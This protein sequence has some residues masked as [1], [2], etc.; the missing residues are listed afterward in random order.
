MGRPGDQAVRLGAMLLSP[1]PAASSPSSSTTER[2]RASLP[3]D[4]LHMPARRPSFLIS[5]W[6]RRWPSGAG[7]S[8]RRRLPDPLGSPCP[9]L[10]NSKLLRGRVRAPRRLITR[11]SSRPSES[12]GW[13]STL[14]GWSASPPRRRLCCSIGRRRTP[15]GTP[16]VLALWISSAGMCGGSAASGRKAVLVLLSARGAGAGG[17]GEL[18]RGALAGGRRRLRPASRPTRPTRPS[19]LE[20]RP[21]RR[22]RS[23]R[24]SALAWRT[25]QR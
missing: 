4:A 14:G 5:E 25:L 1:C 23:G 15:S 20:R 21:W 2:R 3:R 12:P 17:W 16:G 22:A 13:R 7:T 8:A 10:H 24:G 9:I 6:V 18:C 19:V 11:T